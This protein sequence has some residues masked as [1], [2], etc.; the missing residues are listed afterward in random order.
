YKMRATESGKEV[1]QLHIVRQVDNGETKRH[2]SPIPCHFHEIVRAYGHV[3][4][5]SGSYP[6]WVVIRVRSSRSR[7]HQPSGAEIRRCTFGDPGAYGRSLSAAEE[8]YCGLL[9]WR[10][11]ECCIEIG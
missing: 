9:C 10:E 1:V 2:A 8:P 4:Q 7:N 5:V 6:W 11:A 3:E